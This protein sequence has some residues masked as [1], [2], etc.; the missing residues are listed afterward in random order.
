MGEMPAAEE[1][2]IDR[3]RRRMWRFENEMLRP[4]DER[5]LLSGI[6]APQQKDDTATII[7]KSLDGR[8]RKSLPPPI[9]M[10]AGKMGTYREGGVEQQ[11]ALVGPPDKVS[12]SGR[13]GGTHIRID[14]FDDIDKRRRH[15]DSL[16]NRKAESVGLTRLMIRILSQYH[17]LDLVKR[18][19]VKCRKDICP[20]W[21]D[22]ILLTFRNQEVFE[23]NEIRRIKLRLQHLKPRRVDF[24]HNGLYIVEYMT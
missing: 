21:V 2:A 17:D 19:M 23:L 18:S 6:A 22:G 4:V 14:F 8:I 9:L 13:D 16:R 7:R 11:H 20:L 12:R 10:R 1:A 3:K 5:S 15:L 24:Y